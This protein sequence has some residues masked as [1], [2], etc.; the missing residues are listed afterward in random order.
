MQ[1]VVDKGIDK[2]VEGLDKTKDVVVRAHSNLPVRMW[3]GIGALIGAVV[4]G[5]AAAYLHRDFG[6]RNIEYMP[7]MAYSPA[8]KAQ[9]MQPGAKDN[10]NVPHAIREWGTADLPPPDGTVYRGQRNLLMMG[11]RPGPE[12]LEQARGLENPYADATGAE[13]EALLRRGQR[14]FLMNCEA[15]HNVDGAGDAKVTQFGLGA[16]AIND[17]VVRDKYTDG[18]LF[19]IISWGINTMAQHGTH[20][21][22]DDRWK[23]I[24]Y[25]RSLQGGEPGD[26]N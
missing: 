12:G 24:L 19:H 5:L 10:P 8:W 13:R 9:T 26:G 21:E 18:E 22:F 6:K 17:S 25:L 16:P 7:D 4:L 20:V 3:I 23:V 11:I 1:E 15:C 2:A 14:L